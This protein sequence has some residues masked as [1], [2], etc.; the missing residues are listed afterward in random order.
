MAASGVPVIWQV[1]LPVLASVAVARLRLA[2][3]SGWLLAVSTAQ[4][5]TS[6]PVLAKTMAGVN[7]WPVNK[8]T[9]VASVSAGAMTTGAGSLTVIMTVA[10]AVPTALVA[11]TL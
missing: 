9:A 11:V 7:A 8:V 2:G 5:V 1:T 4:L 10:V 6:P 3:R